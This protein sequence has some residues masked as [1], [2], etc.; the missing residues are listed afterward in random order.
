MT[1]E[2]M[3]L[4]DGSEVTVVHF[5]CHPEFGADRIACM[6]GLTDF[7]SGK[8]RQVPHLRTDE[9]RSVTCKMCQKTADYA[10]ESE[11]LRNLIGAFKIK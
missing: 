11:L 1:P 8:F 10:K 7:A 6:P 9:V 5:L 3:I 4:A 2:T